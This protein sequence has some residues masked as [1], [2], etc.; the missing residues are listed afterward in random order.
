MLLLHKADSCLMHNPVL[1][2]TQPSNFLIHASFPAL[3]IACILC[4]IRSGYVTLMND[5]DLLN[6][7]FLFKSRCFIL[8]MYCYL[9]IALLD[10]HFPS[11]NQANNTIRPLKPKIMFFLSIVNKYVFL[12]IYIAKDFITRCIVQRKTQYKVHSTK[13]I[14][15]RKTEKF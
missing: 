9:L 4:D 3:C 14:V 1:Y 12:H 10:F 8:Q 11:K 2:Q 13:Y 7:P 5:I 15:Q 6:Q